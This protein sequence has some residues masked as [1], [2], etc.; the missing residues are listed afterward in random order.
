MQHLFW[1]IFPL[2]A[3]ICSHFLVLFCQNTFV[4]SSEI[5]FSALGKEFWMPALFATCSYCFKWSLLLQPSWYLCS[6]RGSQ[7][8]CQKLY[9]EKLWN[10]EKRRSFIFPWLWF[11]HI[12]NHN[13][14]KNWKWKSDFGIKD[15]LSVVFSVQM[16]FCF[17][18]GPD[19]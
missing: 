4:S 17:N 10:Y 9:L 7:R 2:R 18:V 19:L 1:N 8:G 11:L 6:M 16:W 3:H 14:L 13:N 5:V 12:V 15:D